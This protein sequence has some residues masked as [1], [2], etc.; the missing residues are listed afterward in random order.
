MGFPSYVAEAQVLQM[1]A[2]GHEI[3]AHTRTH[4]HLSS[5]TT[6]EQQN[7][8]LGSY[9]DLCDLLG[10]C[11]TDFAYPYGDYDDTAIDTVQTTGFASARILRVLSNGSSVRFPA[12]KSDA[13]KY[14]LYSYALS[15]TT[16]FSDVQKVID[17]AYSQKDW[18]IIVFHRI[19]ETGNPI[20]ISHELLQ[21]IVDYLKQKNAKV[22]TNSDGL[23][24]MGLQQ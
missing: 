5:L 14:L 15:S 12:N 19:D 7:E 11:P 3:A 9:N 23:R 21:Q 18:L 1:E 10:H 8:I 24:L 20:S 4:P 16:Q 13:N 17:S 2:T 22:V 6:A